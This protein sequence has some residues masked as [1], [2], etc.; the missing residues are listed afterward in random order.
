MSCIRGLR[1]IPSVPTSQDAARTLRWRRQQLMAAGL[2][3]LS[4]HRLAARTDMDIHAVL[5]L[6][7]TAVDTAALSLLEQMDAIGQDSSHV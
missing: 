1:G 6:K 3:E 5:T 4:A 7:D 2:D